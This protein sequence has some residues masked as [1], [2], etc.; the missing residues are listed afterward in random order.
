MENNLN[1]NV[2]SDIGMKILLVIAIIVGLLV[3]FLLAYKMFIYDKKDN[4]ENKDNDIVNKDDNNK[5][6]DKVSSPVIKELKVNYG[7]IDHTLKIKRELTDKLTTNFYIDNKLIEVITMDT[8]IFDVDTSI[9]AYTYV[10]DSKYLGILINENGGYTLYVF[11]NGK[12]IGKEEIIISK[13]TLCKDEACKNQLN[14]IDNIKFEN[15][16]LSFY[17]SNCIDASDGKIIS[18]DTIRKFDL[19][20]KNEKINLT[21]TDSFTGYTSGTIC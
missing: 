20:I 2:K 14:T 7:S 6:D 19:S 4:K 21:V 8:G 17:G 5:S 16:K 12:F 9:D 11:N 18:T 3:S 15:N 1:D 10:F 13:Q